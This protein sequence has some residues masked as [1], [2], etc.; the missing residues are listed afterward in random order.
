M[1]IPYETAK[2]DLHLIDVADIITT[3]YT[4][5]DIDEDTGENDG[6]WT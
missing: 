2:L 6:E 1:K 5:N 3:S 4:S